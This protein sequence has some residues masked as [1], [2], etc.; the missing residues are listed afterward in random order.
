MLFAFLDTQED[1]SGAAA[2]LSAIP[3]LCKTEG[4]QNFN[5]R[6]S[7][8]SNAA[9]ANDHV[10]C[11]LTGV[12]PECFLVNL[13]GQV[14]KTWGTQLADEQRAAEMVQKLLQGEDAT[15]QAAVAACAATPL[16]VPLL[17]QFGSALPSPAAVVA[18]ASAACRV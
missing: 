18:E 11:N 7:S 12:D 6:S 2:A 9:A 13:A 5:K 1:F 10:D 16:A 15:L 4:I 14:G 3:S 8:S 17:V